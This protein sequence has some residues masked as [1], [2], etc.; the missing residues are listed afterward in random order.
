MRYIV[1]ILDMIID[2]YYDTKLG[3]PEIWLTVY[4]VQGQEEAGRLRVVLSTTLHQLQ[5]NTACYILNMTK[6]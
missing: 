3:P 4:L 5:R 6:K 1:Q 2:L